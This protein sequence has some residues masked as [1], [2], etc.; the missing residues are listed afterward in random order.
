[1]PPLSN[2]TLARMYR[3]DCAA[4]GCAAE[5][6]RL[7]SLGNTPQFAASLALRSPPGATGTERALFEGHSINHGFTDE[8]VWLQEAIIRQAHEAG[9][10]T[11]GK[12]YKQ[13]LA[14]GRGA[15]T[16]EA[17]VSDIS[18][19]REA[20]RRRKHLNC[21]GGFRWKGED[22]DPVPDVPLAESSIQEFA[23]EYIAQ[24][25][26]W[27]NKPQELREMIV[28]THGAPARGRGPKVKIK[29]NRDKPSH[30]V[31]IEGL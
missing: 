31:E 9:I 14:D 30:A 20:F 15:A 28:E 5:F 25:P 26:N 19:V 18:D 29:K 12:V 16:P 24:D 21:D 17:W 22:A 3:A 6:D 13:Q 1:M 23:Q 8:P 4:R 10:S 2:E 7:V 27:R 11:H